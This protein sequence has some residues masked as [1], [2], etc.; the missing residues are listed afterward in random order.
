MM[1][2][3]LNQVLGNSRDYEISSF[4]AQRNILWNFKLNDYYFELPK[5]MY[6]N[7]GTIYCVGFLT[8]TAFP[9]DSI[10]IVAFAPYF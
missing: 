1:N 9:N 4:D 5:V 6:E 8:G 10:K 7:N 2:G 3:Q